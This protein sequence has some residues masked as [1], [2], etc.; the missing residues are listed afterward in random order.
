MRFTMM[1]LETIENGSG[2][3]EKE[4]AKTDRMQQ[5]VQKPIVRQSFNY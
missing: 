5:Y 2:Y 4:T 3:N 1:W